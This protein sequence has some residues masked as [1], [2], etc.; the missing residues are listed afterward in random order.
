MVSF[1]DPAA[2]K[3]KG[4]YIASAGLH[5]FNIW[6]AGG[7]FQDALLDAIST[8]GFQDDADWHPAAPVKASPQPATPNPAAHTP[9]PA[10]PPSGGGNNTDTSQYSQGYE[11]G[12][13]VTLG[14]C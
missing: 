2:F 1:D 4:A 8:V 3:A 12:R 14:L 11:D 5:G 9:A 13:K 7:D 10:A 6:E